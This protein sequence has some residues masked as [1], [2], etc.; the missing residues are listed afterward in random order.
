MRIVFI[1]TVDFSYQCLLKLINLKANIVGV[2]TQP[3]SKFNA[4]FIDLAPL[5]S[6]NLLDFWY[7][8][9]VNSVE[10]IDWIKK[11]QP[12]IVFC[13]GWS[14]LIK[15]ELLN[16]APMGVLG[17][18]PALLPKNRGRH[19]LIWALIL[20]LS[21]TG[22]TF[23]FMDEGADSGD[24]LSQEVITI[25]SSDYAEDLYKKMTETAL[26]QIEKFL[27]LLQKY[28]FK[29]LP[30]DHAI[31]NYW[32]KRSATDGKIDFRMSAET[33]YNLVRALSKP[34]VGA[35][36]FYQDQE[37]KVWQT[38]PHNI[39]SSDEYGKIIAVSE[40]SFIVKT[41]HGSI[42]IISYEGSFVPQLGI[43]L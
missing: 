23:F 28:T 25:S 36:F 6:K 34:Y 17:Y 43:Y 10:S 19:P 13:F 20:G 4:D 32:R 8:K 12:D 33:I 5:A 30:Q 42:E 38:V 29:R 40:D 11:K 37:I 14:S 2:V 27:P 7:T 31:A 41:A 26:L 24:I 35:S 1:G 39:T 22:S 18:H 9:D 21:E 15:N 3:Y 16:L